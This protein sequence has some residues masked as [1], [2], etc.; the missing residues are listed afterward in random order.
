LLEKSKFIEDL[1]AKLTR[2]SS[3]KMKD[4]EAICLPPFPVRKVSPL[5]LRDGDLFVTSQRIYFKYQHDQTQVETFVTS[6]ITELFKRSYQL[7]DTALHLQFT[8]VASPLLLQFATAADRD[9]VY[10]S[11]LK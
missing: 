10:E 2:S 6:K 7:V 9:E 4:D 11:L 1:Q 8:N 5:L 3:F